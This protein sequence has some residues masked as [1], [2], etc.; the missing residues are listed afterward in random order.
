MNTQIYSKE[1]DY[2]KIDLKWLSIYFDFLYNTMNI[3]TYTVTVLAYTLY[4]LSVEQ[5]MMTFNQNI[6]IIP[7]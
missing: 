5:T 6:L 1:S 3:L 7:F 4:I 2:A